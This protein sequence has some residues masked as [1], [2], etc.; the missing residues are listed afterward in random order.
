GGVEEPEP[1]PAEDERHAR[2]EGDDEREPVGRPSGGEGREKD[3]QRVH[4]RDE[5][6]EQ[7]EREQ[8]PPREWGAVVREVAM[9][10]ATM[11][12][13]QVVSAMVVVVPG[14]VVV[15][16]VAVVRMDVV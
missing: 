12:V 9:A 3:D 13:V 14:V 15:P 10:D 6:A 5:T 8:A 1:D 4:A 11:T 7:P 16:M 2:P